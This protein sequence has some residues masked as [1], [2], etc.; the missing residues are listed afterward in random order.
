[1]TAFPGVGQACLAQGSNGTLTCAADPA[2]GPNYTVTRQATN[3]F[4]FN[5]CACSAFAANG[6]SCFAD[7]HCSSGRCI[8]VAYGT[9]TG[10]MVTAQPTP[11]TCQ[12]KLANDVACTLD[13][14]CTSGFCFTYDT[15][16]ATGLPAP[17]CKAKRV[18]GAADVRCLANTDCASGYCD[19][20]APVGGYGQCKVQASCP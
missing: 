15:N 7:E 8:G 11:G 2:F 3:Q 17:L 6:T 19:V 4:N 13:R 20:S 12:P 1:V 16:Q 10:N 14:D 5:T 9:V 18:N